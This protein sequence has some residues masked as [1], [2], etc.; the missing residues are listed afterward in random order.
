[1]TRRRANIVPSS[2][3]KSA[4]MQRICEFVSPLSNSCVARARS[5]LVS[6]TAS[7]L[8]SPPLLMRATSPLLEPSISATEF[9]LAVKRARPPTFPALPFGGLISGMTWFSS[10][11]RT[12]TSPPI[13]IKFSRASSVSVD[14]TWPPATPKSRGASFRTASRSS[15]VALMLSRGRFD[16]SNRLPL[17]RTLAS[18]IRNLSTS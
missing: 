3:T 4:T 7:L 9:P 2:A 6:T 1:M 17:N 14:A 5:R 18:T 15:S 13:L 10:M 11:L 12:V 8:A 16:A